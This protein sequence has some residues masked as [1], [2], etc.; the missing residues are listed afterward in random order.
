MSDE[1]KVDPDA[2]TSAGTAFRE[3]G[4]ALAALQLDTP[5]NTAARGLNSL[6]TASAC[7]AAATALAERNTAAA[8]DAA[9]LGANLDTAAAKYRATDSAAAGGIAGA[10]AGR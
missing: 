5:L 10:M 2:L 3:A 9:S 4:S 6:Q 1:L 8:A 7:Q